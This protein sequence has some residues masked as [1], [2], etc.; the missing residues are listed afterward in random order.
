M[1]P[2]YR[3]EFFVHGYHVFKWPQA[4]DAWQEKI[5]ETQKR[6]RGARVPLRE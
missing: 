1:Y 6:K 3:T 4:R 5:R 2:E